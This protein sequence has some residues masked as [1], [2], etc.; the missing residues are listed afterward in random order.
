V[1]SDGERWPTLTLYQRFESLIAFIL[2]LIVTLV[3]LVALYRLVADVVGGLVFGALNPLDYRVFQTVFG[4]IMTVLIALEFNHTLQYVVSREQSIIQTK[5]V[6]LIS[7][8]ALARKFIILDLKETTPNELSGLAA[9][10]LALGV[11]YWLLRDRDDRLGLQTKAQPEK[12]SA[13]KP[14]RSSRPPT[15]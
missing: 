4:E 13:S 7:L 15:H 2:T 14:P 5:I 10:T 8:L 3:I 1:V 12:A 9:V 6:L 11:T